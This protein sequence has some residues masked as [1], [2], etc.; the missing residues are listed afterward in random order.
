MMA[1]FSKW[2]NCNAALQFCVTMT[3]YP[4]FTLKVA[5]LTEHLYTDAPTPW[6]YPFMLK[7]Q[8]SSTSPT[9]IESP[10]RPCSTTAVV[11]ESA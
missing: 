11:V 9:A 1:F 4:V 5:V 7:T 8:R 10:W 2:K 6:P 3:Y